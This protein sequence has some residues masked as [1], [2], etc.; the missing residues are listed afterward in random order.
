MFNMGFVQE[1]NLF[2]LAISKVLY[3]TKAFNLSSFERIQFV[4]Q[5]S[6]VE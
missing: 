5:F 2:E 6:V 4:K 3:R 1:F